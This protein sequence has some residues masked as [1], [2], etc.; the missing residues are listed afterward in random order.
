MASSMTKLPSIPD[1]VSPAL[2]GLAYW[3]GSQHAFGLAENIS[4]GACNQ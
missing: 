4:E 3:L 1:W 2:Q